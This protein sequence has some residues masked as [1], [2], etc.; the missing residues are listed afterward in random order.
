MSIA[1]RGLMVYTAKEKP[2]RENPKYNHK[3]KKNT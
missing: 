3:T 1:Q 2:K